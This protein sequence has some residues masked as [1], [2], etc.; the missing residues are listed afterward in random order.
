MDGRR[1]APSCLPRTEA[2]PTNIRQTTML[3]TEEMLETTSLGRA[4]NESSDKRVRAVLK[5]I[6]AKNDEARKEAESQLLTTTD[7]KEGPNNTKSLVPRYTFCVNCEKEFD[8]TAN[9]EKSCQYH[10]G[11]IAQRDRGPVCIIC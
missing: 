3:G 7:T 9:T 11:T 10:P 8:V 4:I 1:I 2:K 5:S 6:C